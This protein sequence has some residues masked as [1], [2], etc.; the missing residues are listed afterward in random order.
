MSSIMGLSC[1]S[2][3]RIVKQW[4]ILPPRC[5][6]NQYRSVPT[7]FCLPSARA[8][9]ARSIAPKI[10]GSMRGRHQGPP[11]RRR[12]IQTP[13]AIRARPGP[14]PLASKHPRD[15]RLRHRE[16]RR[17][18]PGHRLRCH[19]TAARRDAARTPDRG[20]LL[21]ARGIPT[22]PF[23]S[24]EG[25]LRRTTRICPSR[26]QAREHFPARRWAGEDSDFDWRR[27]RLR[28]PLRSPINRR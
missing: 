11:G 26:S 27:P 9:W 12:A 19:G 15:S 22:R 3:E 5:P 10:R 17:E 28:Q 21:L 4:I 20:A 13:R 2:K 1:G 8:E 16:Q 7:R 18:R 23:R 25:W 24:R 6:C 14:S